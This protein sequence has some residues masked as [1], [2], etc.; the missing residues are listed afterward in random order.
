[1]NITKCVVRGAVVSVCVLSTAGCGSDNPAAPTDPSAGLTLE[2]VSPVELSATVA[3]AVTPVP[4]V[5]VRD[6]RGKAVSGVDVRFSVDITPGST[7][8]IANSLVKTNADGIATP[9]SWTVGQYAGTQVLNATISRFAPAVS[10]Q[11]L[12]LPD[13]PSR[14][15]LRR[16][17]GGPLAIPQDTVQVVAQLSDRFGNTVRRAGVVVTFQTAV[18]G[19]TSSLVESVVDEAGL[20]RFTWILSSAPGDNVLTISAPG[21]RGV[22]D[23]LTVVNAAGATFYDLEDIGSLNP[24]FAVIERAVI[25]L[26]TD[27][28]FVDRL[29]GRD[30]TELEGVWTYAGRY[31][32]QKGRL[33]LIMGDNY[34]ESGSITEDGLVV[35]RW[36]PTTYSCCVAWK[37]KK[38]Q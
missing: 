23:T 4:A 26:G 15:T 11:A 9:G 14:V 1:M 3:T 12:V 17:L 10:F 31:E 19:G 28:T 20:A 16:S 34:Q 37:Y 6:E 38:R 5:I 35:E 2:A 33:I 8:W 25:L 24:W 32:V 21:V 13:E 18:Q 30:E 27:G 36:D 7:A 22:S 29:V